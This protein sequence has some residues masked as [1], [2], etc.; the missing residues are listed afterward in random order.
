MIPERPYRSAGD[1]QTQAAKIS[2]LGISLSL[3]K[4][5]HSHLLLIMNMQH[6]LSTTKPIN[7]HLSTTH[8][9]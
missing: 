7:Y 3:V 5:E 8:H 6:K 9:V 2:L 1:C 4:N